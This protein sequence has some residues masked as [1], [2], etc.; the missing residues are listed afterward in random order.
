MV[1]GRFTKKLLLESFFLQKE[2][3]F[4]EFNQTHLQRCSN[5]VFWDSNLDSEDEVSELS[6]G[7]VDDEEHDGEAAQVLGRLEVVIH[8]S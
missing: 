4:L 8:A 6:E 2:R 7:E 5:F 3:N 1:E